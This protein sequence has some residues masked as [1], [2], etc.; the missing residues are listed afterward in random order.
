VPPVRDA[1]ISIALGRRAKEA[2]PAL[3]AFDA[4]RPLGV[5]V[6]F[7]FCGVHCPYCD[8]AVDDRAVVPHDEY[9]DAVVREIDARAPWFGGQ[10]ATSGS[11]ADLRSI[12]FGGGT[13]GLWRPSA[14]GRVIA[15]VERHFPGPAAR[16]ITVEINP[17]EVDDAHLQAL[18]AVGVNRLSMG[19]QS[20]DDDELRR[21]GRNHDAAAIP[22]AF[23]AARR[24][25]FAN[26]TV[27]LMFA[28]PG[29]SLD[30][31]RRSLAALVALGPEHV[32]AY[33]LT[34]ERGTRFFN[35]EKAGRLQRPDDD[36][37]AEMFRVGREAL[38]AAGYAQYEI[39]SHARPGYRAVHNQL[40]W[41]GGAY[42]GVGASA[43]SFRPLMDGTGWRFSNPRATST[44]LRAAG[45]ADGPAAIKVERRSAID[46]EN[47]ALWLALRTS[48]GVDRGAH[49]R[50]F[51]ADPLSAPGRASAAAAFVH[52]GW[53][54]V[55]DDVVRLSPEGLLFADEVAARLWNAGA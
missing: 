3:G 20:F 31:W 12:Y 14:L 39:S 55:S 21:L 37:A 15:A 43:A 5:Y 1:P 29:Q 44:Y 42:L 25:G 23:A 11:A 26:L 53:L 17:G 19:A 48:D 41:T 2:D 38:A 9:A 8:F 7:P 47:E 27:D 16:E 33:S 24:A 22:R 32:S 6:H 36:A 10:S 46:L 45:A 50:R 30:S 4:A 54:V 13:P 18:K 51:G 34:I 28:I 35:D 49:A 40:Y 52:G